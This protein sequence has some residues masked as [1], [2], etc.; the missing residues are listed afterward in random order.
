MKPFIKQAK[1]CNIQ[2]YIAGD[3]EK[4]IQ[5]TNEY[6]NDVGYCVTVTPT[7]YVHTSGPDEGLPGVIVGLINYPRFPKDYAQL[8]RHA[9]EIAEKLR[10]DLGQESFSIETPEKTIWYSYRE[11]DM[12]KQVM[13]GSDET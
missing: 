3:Y 4:A 2:I 7:K 6:C 8:L 13:D 12:E 5:S 11:E 10:V 1:T 9:I